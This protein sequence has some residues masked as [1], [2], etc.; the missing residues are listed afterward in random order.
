MVRKTAK[1]IKKK[2][3]GHKPNFVLDVNSYYSEFPNKY[4]KIANFFT[5]ADITGRE[6]T[7]DD[8]IFTKCNA[9]NKH[10]ITRNIKDFK[11][12]LKSSIYKNSGVVSIETQKMSEAINV[13][14]KMIKKYPHHEDYKKKY[15]KITSSTFIEVSVSNKKSS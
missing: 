11:Q 5:V 14:G 10:L 3:K 6:N 2:E 13:F 8:D 7:A 9:E 4:G 1:N 15:I 12:N